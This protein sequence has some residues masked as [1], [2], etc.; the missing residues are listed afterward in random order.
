MEPQRRPA[1]RRFRRRL[2]L[3]YVL[4]AAVAGGLLGVASFVIIGEHRQWTFERNARAQ[5]ELSLLSAPSQL[6]LSRFEALLREYRRRGG[7]ETVA[8]A[9]D[10]AFSSTPAL[11]RADVLPALRRR[12]ETTELASADTTINGTRYLVLGGSKGAAEVYFFFSRQPL[13]DGLEGVGEILAL[14]WLIVVGAAGLSAHVVA[15]RTLRPVRW[16]AAEAATRAERLIDT[17]FEPSV[18]DEL[19]AWAESYDRLADALEAKISALDEAARR[20]R[21]FTSDIAHELRTPLTAMLAAASLLEEEI[22]TLP[23]SAQ[24][25]ARLLMDDTRRLER[26]VLELLELARLDA[27]GEVADLERFTLAPVLEAIIADHNGHRPPT[28]DVEPSDLSVVADR[29]RLRRVVGNLVANGVRHGRGNVTVRARHEGASVVIEVLDDGP[30]LPDDHPERIFDRFFKA[31]TSRSSPGAGLGLAIAH[32]N[33]RLQGGT[34]TAE[35]RLSG[36]AKFTLRLPAAGSPS[37][38]ASNAE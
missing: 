21:R 7:F 5:A 3:A 29:F 8:L 4:V 17:R 25:P 24:R 12:I 6:T 35:N 28:L 11:G 34:L 33:A 38:S 27:G 26:L 32:E 9:G 23:S 1:P 37:A 2:T 10:V 20:E 14:G 15:R 18:D 16:A 19:G 31:D 13:A 36:G 22:D 30:G